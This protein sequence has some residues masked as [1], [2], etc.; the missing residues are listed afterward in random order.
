VTTGQ[1]AVFANDA[2]IFR[3]MARNTFDPRKTVY[4]PV[5]SQKTM[6]SPIAS[7]ILRTNVSA[8][9]IEADVRTS[10]GAMV[11]IAQTFYHNWRAFVDGKPVQLWRANYGFQAVEV[12]PGEHR[13]EVVYKDYFF[14]TGAIISLVSLAA[15]AVWFWRM[16]RPAIS[17][18]NF[19]K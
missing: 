14:G 4:L 19:A 6:N 18:N 11:V 7:T 15:I 9:K 13:V 2:D 10:T 5:E 12:P 8:H 1:E 16:R 17:L 3:A